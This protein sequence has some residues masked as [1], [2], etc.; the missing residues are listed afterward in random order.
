MGG[1]GHEP[2][3]V[4]AHA[5]VTEVYAPSSVASTK[6]AT[7][8]RG[9]RRCQATRTSSGVRASRPGG[10]RDG[11]PPELSGP[12]ASIG[13]SAGDSATTRAVTARAAARSSWTTLG[14]LVFE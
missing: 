9:R 14:S 7:P 8:S 11:D 5:V 3:L 13:D 4:A 1:D 12:R 10:V 6:R 2:A